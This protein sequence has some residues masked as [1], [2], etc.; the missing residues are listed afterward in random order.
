LSIRQ[1]VEH[2]MANVFYLTF[3]NVFLAT[4]FYVF[5]VFLFFLERFFTFMLQAFHA[6]ALYMTSN[7]KKNK[8]IF[9]IVFFSVCTFAPSS[10]HFLHFTAA[11]LV[12][13][14]SVSCELFST[15]VFVIF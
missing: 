13:F 12:C 8:K 3:L 11:C 14:T 1:E 6:F 5:N 9:K 4:F 7:Y 10:R 2:I 15:T